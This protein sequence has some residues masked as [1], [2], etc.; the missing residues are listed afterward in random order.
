MTQLILG[1]F[2]FYVFFTFLPTYKN[3]YFMFFLNSKICF[4]Y[5]ADQIIESRRR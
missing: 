3:M 5:Y 4:Y 2:L 1:M